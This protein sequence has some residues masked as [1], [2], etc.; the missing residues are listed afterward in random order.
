MHIPFFN[1]LWYFPFAADFNAAIFHRKPGKSFY[2]YIFNSG[3]SPD[4]SLVMLPENKFYLNYNAVKGLKFTSQ[5]V[6]ELENLQLNLFYNPQ[7]RFLS[8]TAVLNFKE[9]SSVKTVSLDP[10]LVVKG[11]GKSQQHELQLVQPRRHLFPPGPGAEQIQFL[12]CRQRRA[13][14]TTPVK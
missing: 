11:Y 7:V 10:G 12:L 6:D 5:G 8:A 9:P 13:P 1:E 2:R 4:T 14:A 3:N